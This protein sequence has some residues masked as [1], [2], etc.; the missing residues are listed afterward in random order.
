VRAAIL[1]VARDNP[2]ALW[3]QIESL[4]ACEL[5]E[6]VEVVVVDDASGPETQGLLA[7]LEGDVTIRR[8][9]RPIGRRAALAAAAGA[10]T[11]DVCIALTTIARPRPVFV[12]PLVAALARGATLAAPVIE[13]DT[14]EVHGYRRADD[15]SLWPL[16]PGAGSPDALALDCLAARKGWWI[17]RQPLFTAREGHYEPLVADAAGGRIAVAAG[18]RVARATEGPRASVIVCTR[19]RAEEV[20]GC[21]RACVAHGV[22]AGGCELIVVDNGAEPLALEPPAG[23]RVV[24]EPVAGLSRARNAGAAAAAGEILVY[25]DDDARP[26]PGWLESLRDAFIDPRTAIAGGPIHGLWPPQRPAGWPPPGTESLF[27]VLSLGDADSTF[28]GHAEVY[29]ANWAIRASVLAAA[30]GFDP[31]V[32]LRPGTRING[33]EYTVAHRVGARGLGLGRY[34]A[35]AGVGHRVSPDRIDEGYMVA[36]GFTNGVEIVSYDE[37]LGATSERR[38]AHLRQGAAA[39]AGLG[40]EAGDVEG[41][42]RAVHDLPLPVDRRVQAAAALGRATMAATVL[43]AGEI[44][45]GN[46]TLTVRPQ[47]AH[48]LVRLAARPPR[49]PGPPG[50]RE[51]VLFFYPD[52]PEPSRSA[53]HTRAAEIAFAL[54]RLGYRT[55]LACET[56]AGYESAAERFAGSGIEVAAPDRGDDLDALL[57]RGFDAAIVSFHTL[58]ARAVPVLRAVSPRT[59]IAVDSV[60]VHFVRMRRAAELAG[61]RVAVARADHGRAQELAVYAAADVVLAVTED[62]RALL[63]GLLPGADV[64]VLGNVHRVAEAVAPP[65]GRRGALFVGSYAHAPN[66]DAVRW[67]CSDVMP[68]LLAAGHAGPVVVAG[69]GMPDDLAALAATAGA[70]PRGFLPSMEAELAVRRISIAPLRFGAGLKGKVGESLAAGVPVVGTTIAAEG[71]DRPE[72]GML[73]ADTAAAFA[74]A[75][76]R[77][78]TG[79]ELWGRLSAGGRELVSETLGLGACETALEGILG[80][81]LRRRAA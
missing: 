38:A 45:A 72:R 16:R 65:A 64:Q 66:V 61:D 57:R 14:G 41:A 31:D 11:A 76:V 4:V 53:G 55:T 8:S 60:D 19:D 44:A 49:R 42:L 24:R 33:D 68:L 21:I 36:R 27:S 59:R 23:V 69:A 26:G 30:G 73:I 20:A 10:A 34:V 1:I 71:F 37:D 32:G 51:S 6:D 35:G 18:S 3:A 47:D 67:L 48:G 12:D 39:L 13:T 25:L 58:A 70:Q 54:R 63:A 52:M 40:L 80:S 75:V 81:L 15:G 79:D 2:V 77:L 74:E 62:E 9:D 7:R 78:S 46:T 56:C 22:T 29:G 28:P 50:E 17:E 43:G 5:P